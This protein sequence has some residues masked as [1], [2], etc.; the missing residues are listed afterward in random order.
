MTTLN[1]A[2][3]FE[4]AKFALLGMTEEEKSAFVSM[5]E[6]GEELSFLI[7]KNGFSRAVNRQIEMANLA[8]SDPK[9]ME[10]LSA[11]VEERL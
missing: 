7:V 10:S 5:F 3:L 9:T 4:A 6:E 1:K 2:E 8:L 11:L